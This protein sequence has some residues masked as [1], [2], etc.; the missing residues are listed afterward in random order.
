[1]KFAAF[2]DARVKA[3]FKSLPQTLY[4]PLM[5][6]RQYVLDT[7]AETAGIGDLIET[8]KWREPAYL[9]QEPRTGTTIRINAVKGSHDRYAMYSPL[10]NLAHRNFQ[11]Y[12][13]RCFLFRR[14]SGALV[15]R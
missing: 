4:E 2:N 6:L 1:M 10:P 15:R 3:T 12:L 14:Q 9:R 7:A 11:E 8:L 13:S 5:R